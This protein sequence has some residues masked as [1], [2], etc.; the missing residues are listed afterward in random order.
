MGW[1]S[2]EKVKKGNLLTN[3]NN[4]GLNV[5]KIEK[6]LYLEGIQVYNFH[7][8]DFHTYYVSKYCILVHNNSKENKV[9]VSK[10]IERQVKKLSPEAKKGYEKAIQGLKNGDTR[11]LNQHPLTGNRSG[12]FAVDIKG[13]GRGRGGGRIIYENVNGIIRI[14]EILTNH[15]Y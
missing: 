6:N 5:Q 8:E 4:F 12:Q 1:K 14:L 13:L 10:S 9:E 7:V 3:K 11:G 2:A 15:E